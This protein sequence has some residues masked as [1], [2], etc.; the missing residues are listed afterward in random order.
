[1]DLYA[2][3]L[4]PPRLSMLDYRRLVRSCVLRYLAETKNLRAVAC[5]SRHLVGE[6]RRRAGCALRAAL[7]AVF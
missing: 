3:A 4:V 6:L 1:V 7:F 5:R 2:R